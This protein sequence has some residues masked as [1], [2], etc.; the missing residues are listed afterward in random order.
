MNERHLIIEMVGIAGAGKTT[1]REVLRQRNGRIQFRIPPGKP[2]YIPFL[3]RHTF[4][5]LPLYLGK[6]RHSR[7]FTWKE[8]QQMGYLETWIPYLRRQALAKGI[9]VVLDP[10]SVY[11]LTA[12]REFG[13]EIARSQQ[14]ERWWN[15]MF[16]QWA[17]ALDGIIWLDAPDELL[18]ARIL[19][20]DEWH[21]IKEQSQKEARGDFVRYRA[22]YG[23]II[24]AMTA[25]SGL[26]VFHF[27]TDQISSEQMADRV[28]SVMKLK[29][30]RS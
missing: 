30:G 1:L 29:D 16:R 22:Q 18:Y 23:R 27:H 13:P 4:R 15:T 9:V 3:S 17:A 5:W 25:Q 14:Y 7:W 21:E 26:K 2:R 20:R 24:A 11:W 28:L 10:G 19:A 8:I 6:H 12:L